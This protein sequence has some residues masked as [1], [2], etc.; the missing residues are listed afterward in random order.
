MFTVLFASLGSFIE[1]IASSI[2]KFETDHKKESIYTAGFINSLFAI[3]IFIAIALWRD[4]FLFTL[5]SLPTFTIRAVLEIF[6]THATMMAIM[7]AD[8]STYAFIRNL[9]IPLLLIVDLIFGF[10]VSQNQWIGIFVIFTI[11]VVIFAFRILNWCGSAYPLFTAINAVLTISLFK[12]NT[13][14][15]NSVEGEQI[16][17][18]TILLLYF[19]IAACVRA[20]E[21]PL[22]FLRRRLFFSQGF[23]HGIATILESFAIFLGNPGIAIAAKRSSAVLAGIISGHNYF[24]EKKFSAKIMV[25]AGLIIGLILLV[26]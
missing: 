14:H 12:Y 1:E 11:F 16:V 4:S 10:T 23:T 24:Q 21:N 15:F 26:G 17:L 8:R 5:A 22:L 18:I 7:K 20:G 3:I 9:T 6:Q 19:F 13:T 25:C 2:I